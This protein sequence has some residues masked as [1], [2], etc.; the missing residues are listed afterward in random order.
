MQDD[1]TRIPSEAMSGDT[2]E[3]GLSRRGFAALSAA[4]L[5]AA[6]GP[7]LAAQAVETDVTVAT[8]DGS[9]DAALFHPAGA[10]KHPAVIMFVDAGGLRPVKRDMGRRLA[11]EGY[12]V[13]VPNP[14]Y[15]T[16]KAPVR[17]RP[18]DWNNAED[19]AEIA[20]LRAPMTA[21]AVTR[22]A[23]AYIKFLDAR[24]QVN[25]RAKAGSVGYCMGGSMTMR[26]SAAAPDRFGAGCSFHGGALVT[27]TPDSPHLLVPKI[28]AG[29]YFGVAESDDQK[30]PQ[31][32]TVLKEAFEKARNPAKIEVYQGAMHGWCVKGSPVYNEAAA[33]RAWAEMSALFKRR[34]V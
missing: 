27:T 14:Y 17:D 26:A 33:E 21:E 29:Y 34:L 19:R 23:M 6:A 9:C 11:A 3:T 30:E 15:R 24:A 13:L 5:A 22:D 25:T 4:S 32:K 7:A 8:P 16:R 20:A 2:A 12:V 1:D 18:F 31:A 28:K 10:A